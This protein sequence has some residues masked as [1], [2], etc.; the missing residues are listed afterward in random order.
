MATPI[1]TTLTVFL[2]AYAPLS[3]HMIEGSSRY[4]NKDASHFSVQDIKERLNNISSII[5]INYTPEVGRRIKEYTVNYRV[6]GE[7]ILGRVD[8]FFPIFEKAIQEKNL[9][10]DL[11]YVAVVE[12]NLE[13]TAMSKSGAS[14]L[15]QFIKSTG[16]MQG[17]EIN[18]YVDERRD[19]EKSTA[20]A[21]DYLSY[22]YNKFDDWTLALA[23][24]NCGPGNVRKAIRRSGGS[25]DYWVIR[26]HLPNETQKYVPRII[27]AMYL[28]KY[29]H[30]HNLQ[31][32]LPKTELV[33]TMKINDGIGHSFKE[34]ANALDVDYKTLKYLN[35]MYKTKSFPKNDGRHTLIIPASR[36]M[37]YWSKYN[38]DAYRKVIA[39]KEKLKK[40]KARKEELKAR[41]LLRPQLSESQFIDPIVYLKLV[42]IRDRYRV[43]IAL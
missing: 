36:K 22:L 31:P 28:M 23:A 37:M 6:S 30:E 1:A 41:A 3:A 25:K 17:L 34:L 14:G 38:L 8:L 9:P 15:W 4:E 32:T 16:K 13:P 26:K 39:Q 21:L 2:F 10:D 5:D 35:P 24:Y 18:N 11:K 33:N 27:A 29:Y 7:N 20:A 40:D 42:S 19:P 12:S 43:N